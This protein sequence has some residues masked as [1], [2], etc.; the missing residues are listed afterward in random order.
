MTRFR[1]TVILVIVGLS[2]LAFGN[3][4]L[5]SISE[6][7]SRL[8][9][10]LSEI[11]KV[12]VSPAHAVDFNRGTPSSILIQTQAGNVDVPL[13]F[14][15]KELARYLTVPRNFKVTVLSQLE[16]RLKALRQESD[17][18]ERARDGDPAIRSRLNQILAAREFR[19]VH[20]PTQLELLTDYINAWIEKQFDKLFPKTPDLDQLGQIFVWITIAIACSVLAVWLYRRSRERVLDRTREVIPFSASARNWRSWLSEAQARA[21]SG[22][23]REAIHLGFW[24]SVSRLESDGLW[25]PDKTRTPREYLNAIPTENGFRLPFAAVVKM[26]EAAWYAGRPASVAEYQSFMLELEKLGCRG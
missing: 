3:Q 17:Q 7:N 26:F 24:A 13:E 25:E 8:E 2:N 16:E 15:H 5:L 10:Y 4:E 21:A 22:D 11:Q 6:Y 9:Q 14:L 1:I 19:S 12:R 20:G 18:F 23:W